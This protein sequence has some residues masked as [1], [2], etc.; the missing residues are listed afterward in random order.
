MNLLPKTL[1]DSK[2]EAF[3]SLVSV[4]AANLQ[5]EHSLDIFENPHFKAT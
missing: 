1:V 4:Y 3:A 2:G 5:R